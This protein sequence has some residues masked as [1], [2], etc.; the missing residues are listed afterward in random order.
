M[1]HSTIQ[2]K[3]FVALN[4]LILTG[5]SFVCLYPMIYVILASLSES[6][7]LMAYSGFLWKPLSPN[8]AAYRAIA[9]NKM[10]FTGYANTLFVVVTATVINIIMT[11]L[12]AYVLSRKNLMLKKALMIYILITMYFSGG[13]IPLYL[14][15]KNLGLYNSLWSLILPVAL[16]TYNLI[17]MRTSFEA[18]PDSLVEAALI[19]G[20]NHA[21]I[22]FKVVLPLAKATVAVMVLYYGVAHWNSWF[23]A[24]I[25]LQSRS[26]YPLQLVLK[27]ILIQNDTNAMTQGGSITDALDVA[28]TIKYAV[29]VVATLPIL[30]AYPF[31][32]KYLAKGA[33]VGAVKG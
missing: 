21:T 33:L 24:S 27:E 28:E 2:R 4:A 29:I 26:K 20:A 13:I 17:I 32:Q 5:F 19:D 10:I 15:V 30:C 14:T 31:L 3:I 18:I 1:K 25:Y 22:M 23:Q 11:S 16:N 6:S 8:L 7:K 9:I 12:T